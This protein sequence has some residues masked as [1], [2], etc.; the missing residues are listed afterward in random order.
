MLARFNSKG[1]S[2]SLRIELFTV[3]RELTSGQLSASGESAESAL[4]RGN[5][6]EYKLGMAP[7]GVQRWPTKLRRRVTFIKWLSA[8]FSDQ[9]TGLLKRL[10]QN[11]FTKVV[12][13]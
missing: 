13:F 4:V 3:K 8:S 7:V 5:W 6:T 11:R 10:E 1:F 9:T 2:L 12:S